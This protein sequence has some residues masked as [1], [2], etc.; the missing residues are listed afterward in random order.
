MITVILKNTTIGDLK[1]AGKVIPASGQ[2]DVSDSTE[3]LRE[4]STLKTDIDSGDIVVNDGSNDL[5][6]EAGKVQ[7]FAPMFGEFG[8]HFMGTESVTVP[9]G[10][11]AERPTAAASGMIRYNTTTAKFECCENGSWVEVRGSSVF[12]TEFQYAEDATESQT[13]SSDWVEKMNLAATGLPNGTYRVEFN[14]LAN[15]ISDS[16]KAHFRV[17]EDGVK[18]GQEIT[19]DGH[20]DDKVAHTRVIHR[21]V[22]GN[23]TWG[24]EYKKGIDGAEL[25]DCVISA[26]R[27]S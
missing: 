16:D 4:N 9:A 27:V 18:V 22:S 8:I 20:K 6:A 23:V 10:T 26:W 25:A 13:T 24:I 14:F 12:G 5:G 3:V 19:M 11:T 21:T 2:K 1:Y 17:C 15:C 7:M